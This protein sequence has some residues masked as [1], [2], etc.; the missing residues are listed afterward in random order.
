MFLPRLALSYCE[1]R[2]FRF[3]GASRLR[4]FPSYGTCAEKLKE[5][6]EKEEDFQKNLLKEQNAKAKATGGTE[7][8][9]DAL[10]NALVSTEGKNGKKYKEIEQGL[11]KYGKEDSAI[12]TSMKSRLKTAYLNSRGNDRLT[13]KYSDLLRDFGVDTQTIKGWLE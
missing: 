3:P 11:K 13:K 1:L 9:Y 7:Y 2:V 4:F 5:A 8:S 6:G 12:K 10:F